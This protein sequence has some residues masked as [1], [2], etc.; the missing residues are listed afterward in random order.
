M[1]FVLVE[2]EVE[3]FQLVSKSRQREQCQ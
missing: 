1:Y 3:M 2:Q